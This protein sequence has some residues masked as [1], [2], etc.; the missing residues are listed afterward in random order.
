MYMSQATDLYG[1]DEADHDLSD[2]T[3]PLV[4][5]GGSGQSRC[6]QTRRRVRVSEC[7]A[8]DTEKCHTAANY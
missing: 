2:S 3:I 4:D 5:D 1:E 8:P 7:V 6:R